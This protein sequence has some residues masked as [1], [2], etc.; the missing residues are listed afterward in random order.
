MGAEL[1]LEVVQ[2][3]VG[4][5]PFGFAAEAFEAF[6]EHAAIPGAVVNRDA[7]GTRDVAPEAPEVVVHFFLVGGFRDGDDAEVAGIEG[8]GEAAD[9]A[10]LAGGI[11]AFEDPDDGAA[12][13]GG[14]THGL[15]EAA[16]PFVA[17]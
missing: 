17:F 8:A 13:L 2:F 11:P 15:V 7:A 12:A 5:L 6:D 10:A 4:A 1:R 14:G 3:G 16:E 9:R